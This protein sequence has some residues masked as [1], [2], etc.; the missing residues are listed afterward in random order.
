MNISFELRT[1]TNII[2]VVINYSSF[3]NTFERKKIV[4]KKRKT[5]H[6]T[7]SLFTHTQL[8]RLII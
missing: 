4:S 1:Y 7:H 8:Y 2:Q 3:P 6:Y 5:H